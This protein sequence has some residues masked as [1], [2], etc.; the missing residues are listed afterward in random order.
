MD[1]LIAKVC[2]ASFI[3]RFRASYMLLVDCGIEEELLQSLKVS[4]M[5][6]IMCSGYVITKRWIRIILNVYA[7]VC[8]M[9]NDC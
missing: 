2:I 1:L 7:K 3:A 8:R 5:G 6:E 9:L 4:G